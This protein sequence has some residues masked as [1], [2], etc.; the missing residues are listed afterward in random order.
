[1]A[2]AKKGTG[3]KLLA[4]AGLAAGYYFYASKNAKK[5]RKIAAKWASDMKNTV[6]RQAKKTRA[7]N[8]GQILDIIDDAKAAFE[9]VRSVD[10]SEL[11]RAAKELKA[12][13]KELA[14]EL[15]PLASDVARTAK[16]SA[17][18]AVSSTKKHA[19]KA[20]KTA[21]KSVK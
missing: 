16:K 6:I 20:V 13:W 4:A 7:V 9:T 19:R 17:R 2:Q 1:M 11:V 10:R 5:N 21:K 18:K 3:I 15:K 14:G 12:N 8:R